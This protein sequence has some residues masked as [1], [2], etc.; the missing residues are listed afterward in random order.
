MYGMR[1]HILVV[2]A[3][4]VAI[5]AYF[6]FSHHLTA[7]M[8]IKVGIIHSL[9]GTMAIS[10]KSV[11]DAT[12]LALEEINNSGGILGREIQAIVVDTRSNVSEF[13]DQAERLINEDKVSVLFGCWT[14]S[15]RKVVKEVVER[16]Q[17][18]LFYPVQYEGL[19]Q[20]PNIIYTGAAPNQQIIPAVKW[21]FDHLGDR[22]FLVGSDY[23]FPRTANAIIRDQVTALGGQ[24]VGEHYVPLGGRHFDRIVSHILETRPEVIL[25]TINGDSNTSFFRA[26]RMAGITPHHIP[27]LSF[28]VAEGELTSLDPG[29]MAGDYAA[30]NYFQGINNPRNKNFVEKFRAKFGSNRV[31]DDPMEAAYFG[32]YLWA[33]AVYDAQTDEVERV[34]QSILDQSFAAPEGI[35]YVDSETRH[36]WKTVRVGKIRDDGQFDVVWTSDHPVR[37]V[38]FPAY[39]TQSEW[40]EFLRGL[41]RMWGNQWAAGPGLLKE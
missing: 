34:N 25:N 9:T 4:F 35:V 6:L 29:V 27:T 28:S 11:V 31:T 24:I 23:V 36:T 33:Q 14:S 38:P 19:E 37:P 1:K 30:W 15:S 12:M 21:A 2:S 8:P 39:R 26:L 22:F 5:G 41:Y 13:E 18:L 17:H 32:V 3:I 16:F 40:E 20:S 10:E 7:R